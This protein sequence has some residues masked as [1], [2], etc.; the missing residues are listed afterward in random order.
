L[1]VAE[2]PKMAKM[3]ELAMLDQAGNLPT[4]SMMMPSQCFEGLKK[5]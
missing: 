5:I 3:V 2:G 4:S 1:A